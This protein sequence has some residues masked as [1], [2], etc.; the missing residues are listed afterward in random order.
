MPK[1]SEFSFFITYW[2]DGDGRQVDQLDQK[3]VSFILIELELQ[4][5]GSPE[6]VIF[7]GIGRPFFRLR[8]QRG[9]LEELGRGA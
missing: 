8:G 1:K 2:G 9:G 4:E 3:N 7:S 5:E 6:G